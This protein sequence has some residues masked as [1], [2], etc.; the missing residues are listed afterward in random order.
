MTLM[1]LFILFLF[2]WNNSLKM[3]IGINIKKGDERD[4][5]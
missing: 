2:I 1:E 3:K 4:I 5:Y